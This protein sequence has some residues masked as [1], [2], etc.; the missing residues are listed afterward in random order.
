[1]H[2]SILPVTTPPGQPRG[3]VQPFGP[4][5]GELFEAVLSRGEGGGKSKIISSCSCKV[6]HFPVDAAPLFQRK[7]S[8]ISS[9]LV[10]GEQSLKIKICIR[11]YVYYKL[12][13]DCAFDDY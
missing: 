2:G 7:I 12:L 3:Q 6:R 11:R 4:G 10:R 1:M 13:N 9:R 5:G 8:R